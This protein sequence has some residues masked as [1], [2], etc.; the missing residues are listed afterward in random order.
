MIKTFATA[1]A[2]AIGL[3]TVGLPATAEAGPYFIFHEGHHRNFHGHLF[4]GPQFYYGPRVVFRHPGPCFGLRVRA[5][6]TGNP[7]WWHRFQVCRANH[8][9]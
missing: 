3:S 5:E 6:E 2:L 9:Y 1:M 8:S 7:Y 4:F